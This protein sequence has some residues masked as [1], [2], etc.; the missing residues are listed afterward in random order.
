M[1]TL[2]VSVSP[3]T[4]GTGFASRTYLGNVASA[5]HLRWMT[6]T[7]GSAGETP[8]GRPSGSDQRHAATPS[9]CVPRHVEAWRDETSAS[10][11]PAP[12]TRRMATS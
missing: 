11:G 10:F 7:I 9:R 5:K 12:Q 4:R 3:P 8:R 1:F 2:K 6:T